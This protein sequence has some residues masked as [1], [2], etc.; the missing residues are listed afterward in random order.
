MLN[1]Y[2]MATHDS[3][4]SLLNGEGAYMEASLAG[5]GLHCCGV[6]IETKNYICPREMTFEELSEEFR[7]FDS[8]ADYSFV[9]QEWIML[10]DSFSL[11][12]VFIKWIAVAAVLDAVIIC[13]LY[14]SPSP[15]D[16]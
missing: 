3:R 7:L 9:M 6:G 15:R 16:S 14:T 4:I 11:L 2:R 13:L 12:P 8:G 10:H 5:S 1:Q